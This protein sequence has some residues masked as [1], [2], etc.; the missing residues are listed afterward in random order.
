ML[1]EE[2]TVFNV[3]AYSRA[4]NVND[5]VGLPCSMGTLLR[6]GRIVSITSHDIFCFVGVTTVCCCKISVILLKTSFNL[7][8]RCGESSKK[9]SMSFII[10]LKIRR[11]PLNA[12]YVG[13]RSVGW[14]ICYSSRSNTKSNGNVNCEPA[15]FVWLSYEPMCSVRLCVA[16]YDSAASASWTMNSLTWTA[17]H[18]SGALIGCGCANRCARLWPGRLP[19]S[20]AGLHGNCSLGNYD[21]Y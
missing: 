6:S 9:C 19:L 13:A 8:S 18:R 16:D 10:I 14:E 12:R 15:S 11:N 17:D 2:D 4:C 20:S 7:I 5:T 1:L 3:T 21:L